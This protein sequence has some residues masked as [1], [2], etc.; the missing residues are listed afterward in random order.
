MIKTANV[1]IY[2]KLVSN[3]H[4]SIADA[5]NWYKTV[6]RV[7]TDSLVTHIDSLDDQGLP[8]STRLVRRT[9]GDST[10]LI[11]PLIRDILPN[12]LQKLSDAWREVSPSGTFTL[13]TNPT[14]SQKMNQ[15]VNGLTLDNTEYQSLC[16]QLAKVRHEGWMRERSEAGWSY[17]TVLSLVSK[18]HPMLRPWDELPEQYRDVDTRN[19]ENFLDFINNQGYAV[20]RKEELG[21]LLSILRKLN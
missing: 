16:L 12:E 15:A 18:T 10:E 8:V 21:S 2:V 6:L 11:V 13:T 19:P 9:I 20:V 5:R 3:H 17:G 7:L 1:P 4:L 14:Q